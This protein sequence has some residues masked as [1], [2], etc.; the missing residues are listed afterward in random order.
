METTTRRQRLERLYAAWSEL[1]EAIEALEPD[2]LAGEVLASLS[3]HAETAF[4]SK[5][6]MLGYEPNS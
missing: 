3:G 4:M 6:V 1:G 2:D 5:A